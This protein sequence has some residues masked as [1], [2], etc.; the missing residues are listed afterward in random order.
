MA[1]HHLHCSEIRA[2]IHKMRGK[3]MA[4][5]VRR[6]FLLDSGVLGV[7]FYGMPESLTGHHPSQPAWKQHCPT[8]GQ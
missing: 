6:D 1:E 8:L 2:I 7:A 5:R 4:K 3:C